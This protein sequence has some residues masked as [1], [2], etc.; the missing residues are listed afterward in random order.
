MNRILIL[1]MSTNGGP[2]QERRQAIL[3]SFGKTVD[4]Y[5][6]IDLIFYSEAESL[7]E[8][9]IKVE[10]DYI[11]SYPDNETK[12]VNVFNKI[13]KDFYDSYDWFLFI[14]DDTFVNVHLLAREISSFDKEYVHG[15][16]IKGQWNDLNYLSGGAGCLIS[17]TV[18]KH[19]FN[20]KHYHTHYGDV[21]LGLNIRDRNLKIKNDSRF[22]WSNPW[23]DERLDPIKYAQDEI[24]NMLTYHYISPENM[25]I[26]SNLVNRAFLE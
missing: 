1:S 26:L 12:H 22:Y 14:D 17:N 16:N 13:Q 18:V 15:M 5:P 21:S 25:I 10:G 6:D 3:A 4:T 24:Q 20:M 8:R 23:K 9:M 2:Y 19:L 7:D 11:G